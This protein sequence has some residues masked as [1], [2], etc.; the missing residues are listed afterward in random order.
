MADNDKNQ[1]TDEVGQ[2]EFSEKPEENS[3]EIKVKRN[4]IDQ[5]TLT[6]NSEDLSTFLLA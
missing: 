4:E 3:K 6:G 5:N 1:K 2:N